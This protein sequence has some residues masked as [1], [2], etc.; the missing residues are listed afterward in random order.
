MK[1][2]EEIEKVKSELDKYYNQKDAYQKRFDELTE[3]LKPVPRNR[4]KLHT[5]QLS[6][7]LSPRE[8]KVLRAEREDLKHQ[9]FLIGE[10]IAAGEKALSR[11]TGKSRNYSKEKMLRSKADGR[12]YTKRNKHLIKAKLLKA[13]NTFY[14][15]SETSTISNIR[16]FARSDSPEALKMFKREFGLILEAIDPDTFIMCTGLLADELYGAAKL[17]ISTRNASF[18]GPFEELVMPDDQ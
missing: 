5:T 4:K 10:E 2:S 3:L 15:D 17:T 18:R 6:P 7:S 8:R 14:Q 11:L 13:I 1:N 16:T 9:L 12:E